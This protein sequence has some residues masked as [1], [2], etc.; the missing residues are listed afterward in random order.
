MTTTD[1]T[2]TTTTTTTT[3]SSST[4][5]TVSSSSDI[6]WDALIEAAVAEKETAADTIDSKIE[7]NEATIAAYEEMQTLLQAIVDAAETIRGTDSSL[8]ANDDAFSLREA[9]LTGYGDVDA[10]SAI[11]VTADADAEITSYDITIEQLATAQKVAGS[12]YED[13]STELELSGTIS[14]GLDSDD[15]EMVEVEIDEDMTLD[16]IAE[17]INL[18]TDESGVSASVLEVSDGEYRLIL[19]AADTGMEIQYEDTSGDGLGESLGLVDEDGA[20]ANELQVAQNS[21]I[22]IDGIEIT[23]SSNTLDDVIDGVT[24]TLYQ[25]TEDD[26]SINVEISNDLTTI[27]TAITDLVDAYNAYREWAL[28]QAETS[29]AGG[30]SDDS[31][32]FG[33]ST[34]RAVNSAVAEALSTV[35]DSDSMALLGLSYDEYNYL[36]LDET[37]L[38]EALLENLDEVEALISF[39]STIDSDDLVVLSRSDDMPSELTL[40]IEVD[41]EGNI[42]SVSVNGDDTLFEIDGSRIIGADG[43]AY[44]D[45]TFVFTGTESQTVNMTFSSGIMEKL[46]TSING[47]SDADDGILTDMITDLE[48]TNEDLEEEASEIRSNAEDYRDYL[49]TLY[50]EYQ[51]QIDEAQSSLDYLEALLNSGDD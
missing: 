21:I 48:E 5:S 50:A 3:S 33:D 22:T 17:A 14:I 46:Y 41:D 34:L 51:A 36:E 24:F 10:E 9:Y 28:T 19:S 25:A 39:T 18:T 11:V 2:S 4:Y 1:S 47:Y 20:W 49:T 15:Y 16:E 38:N 7:D 45:I 35:I 13:K 32:L 6:D 43:T 12:S 29:S 40:D 37:T 27:K 23:R 30:A 44:E 8:T 26:A 31:V 42:T